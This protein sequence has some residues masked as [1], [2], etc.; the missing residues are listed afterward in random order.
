M[1]V[2]NGCLWV[3]EA[4]DSATTEDARNFYFAQK[5]SHGVL[6][7][8][9]LFPCRKTTN[10]PCSLQRS[11]LKKMGASWAQEGP[12]G[13]PLEEETEGELSNTESPRRSRQHPQKCLNRHSRKLSMGSSQ[14]HKGG[15]HGA[16]GQL[17]ELSKAGQSAGDLGYAVH[18]GFLAKVHRSP[19][20]C[21]SRST[22]DYCLAW[23]GK[24]LLQPN[25][26]RW[27]TGLS[28][29]LGSSSCVPQTALVKMRGDPGDR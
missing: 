3:E 9:E 20:N 12:G 10:M 11:Q 5:M 29:S 18:E 22:P 16:G 26:D 17:S 8:A 24:D 27:T 2:Q 15:S 21:S 25:L 13:R 1:K 4:E 7:D 6:E 23:G 14:H 28:G 19:S